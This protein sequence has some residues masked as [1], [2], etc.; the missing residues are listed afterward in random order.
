MTES[1]NLFRNHIFSKLM[2]AIRD[3]EVTQLFLNDNPRRLEFGDSNK[4]F[5]VF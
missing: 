3:S 5:L 4:P 2:G 1:K